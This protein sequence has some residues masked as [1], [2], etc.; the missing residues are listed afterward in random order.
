MSLQSIINLAETVK[1]NRRKVVGLQYTRNEIA[2]TSELITRNPWRFTV[3]VSALLP[4]DTAA[5]RSI[6]EQLDKI[7]RKTPETVTFSH[8]SWM[9]GY[10]GQMNASEQAAIRVVRLGGGSNAYNELEVDGLP[11]VGPRALP[12]AI[13]FEKGDA[14]QVAGQPYPFTVTSRVLRGSGNSVVLPLHRYSFLDPADCVDQQLIIGSSVSFNVLCTNMPTYSIIPGGRGGV[15]RF[16][17][18]FELYEYTG[19]VV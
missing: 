19:S 13:L 12:T 1:I 8:I 10:N 6:L 3:S 9:F 15:V 2:R 4:Y 17:D 14:V 5:T 7:D 11:V 16:D 18:D